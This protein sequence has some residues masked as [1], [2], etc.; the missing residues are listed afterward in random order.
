MYEYETEFVVVVVG[1]DFYGVSEV[2]VVSF[3]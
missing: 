3:D 2:V 1:V